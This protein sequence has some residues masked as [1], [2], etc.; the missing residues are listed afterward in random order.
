MQIKVFTYIEELDCFLVTPEFRNICD[1]LGLR[2]WEQ[3]A[4]IG[5]YFTLDNDYGEHW[6]DNW[7]QR[8][9]RETKAK[10]LDIEYEDMLI[11]D[12]QRFRN[13]QDGPCHSDVEIKRFWT[14]VLRSLTLS[15]EVIFAE[16][17]LHHAKLKEAGLVEDEDF[18]S[19]L[20]IIIESIANKYN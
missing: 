2:G 9:E 18:V 16:A 12:P 1:Q 14:S 7:E 8:D 10:D 11:I 3:T 15:L 17:R 6:L 20:E 4:W 13:G 5:R 19:D